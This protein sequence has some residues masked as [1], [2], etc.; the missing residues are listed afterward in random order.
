MT[1]LQLERID[2][3]LHGVSAELANAALDG[4]E[5]ALCRRLQGLKLAPGVIARA[6]ISL[7]PQHLPRAIDAAAMRALL[8][9]QIVLAVEH[10][11]NR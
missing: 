1:Q 10:G 2:I 7:E 9:E 8:V 11:G 5:E 3:R 4:L 6:G